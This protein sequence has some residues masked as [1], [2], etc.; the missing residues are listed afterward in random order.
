MKAYQEVSDM[1]PQ[2]DL[3]SDRESNSNTN[4][5]WHNG[6]E[7]PSAQNAGTHFYAGNCNLSASLNL[8]DFWVLLI[9]EL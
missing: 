2:N 4:K 3:M 9:E 6:K 8:D 7:N 1:S 5:K